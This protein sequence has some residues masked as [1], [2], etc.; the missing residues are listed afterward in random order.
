MKE[1]NLLAIT[2]LSGIASSAMAMVPPL[3][4][5]VDLGAEF[6]ETLIKELKEQGAS[7]QSLGWGNDRWSFDSVK[8]EYTYFEVHTPEGGPV[9]EHNSCVL[10][11]KDGEEVVLSAETSKAFIAT[12]DHFNAP[13]QTVPGLPARIYTLK[14]LNANYSQMEL[15]APG[16]GGFQIREF[17][18]SSIQF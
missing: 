12:L 15:V 16:G 14:D 7:S 4:Y 6:S 1:L 2:L 18:S 3:H 11:A 13:H 10:T 17:F 8:C 5:T 9:I